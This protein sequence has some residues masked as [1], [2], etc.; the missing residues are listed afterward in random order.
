MKYG[1]IFWGNSNGAPKVF[2]VQ[3]KILRIIYN[4]KPRDSC[5]ELFQLKQMMTM[6]SL[7][8]YSLI[9]FVINNGDLESNSAIHGYNTRNKNNFH[10]TNLNLTKVKK[11]PY[12]SCIK[13]YNH[14][15]NSI[16]VHNHNIHKF[17][18][19]LKEFFLKHPF[20]SLEEYFKYKEESN[21]LLSGK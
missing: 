7:Y 14:L 9:L 5:R 17:K 11:G 2:I 1:I 15:P 20:Y 6:Y 19:I 4:L 21:T 10:P 16:K 13:M 18:I 3:K 12:Y 8:I